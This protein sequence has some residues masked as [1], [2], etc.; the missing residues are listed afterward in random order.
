MAGNQTKPSDIERV[1]RRGQALELRAAG[2]TYREIADA[3]GYSSP[4]HAHRDIK[5]ELDDI[6]AAPAKEVLGEELDRLDK[7]MQRV[8]VLVGDLQERDGRP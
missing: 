7:M 5:K 8:Q 3:L 4:Q 2:R 6:V 1:K